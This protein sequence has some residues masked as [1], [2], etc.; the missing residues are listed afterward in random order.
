[1]GQLT[2]SVVAQLS[3]LCAQVPV[4]NVTF[5][6]TGRFPAVVYLAPAPADGL[7]QLTITIGE[8][9]PQAPPYAGAFEEVIPHLTIAHCLEEDVLAAIERE[10]SQALPISAQLK[11]AAL[12]IFDGAQ[13]RPW[14]R[15]PFRG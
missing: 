4:L 1:M 15:L 8:Q 14:A 13:W 9:W 6:R 10:A 7:R 5:A 3:E 11:E 12:F 2:D